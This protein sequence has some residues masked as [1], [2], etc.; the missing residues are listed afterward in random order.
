[1]DGGHVVGESGQLSVISSQKKQ[2]NPRSNRSSRV[3]N[4]LK[5][6]ADR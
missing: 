1:M 6:N 2:F 5:L 4:F 3:C